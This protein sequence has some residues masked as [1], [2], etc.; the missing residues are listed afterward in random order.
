MADRKIE[1]PEGVPALNTYY[2]YLTGGCNLACQHC[3]LT[4]AYQAN[5]GTGGHLDYDLFALAIEEGLPLGLGNVKLTGGEPLLHPDFIRIVDLLREKELGLTIET[6]GVLMT[7]PLAHYLKEKST[8][9]HISVSLDGAT[10]GTHDPFRG[11][12]GSFDKAVQGIRY[13]VEAGFHPQVI[14][15]LHIGNVDEIEALIQLAV[16]SGA[17]SVK[18][19]L[20]QPTGRGELMTKRGRVLDIQRLIELGKWVEGDLQKRTSISLHYSWPMAFYNLKRLTNSNLDTCG[21][22]GIL[23]ILSTGHLAMCGMGMQIDD[24]CYGLLGRDYIADIWMSHPLLV[25]LRR[26]LPSQLEGV[27]N[28]CIFRDR[29]LGSCIAGNY[30]Y[31]HALTAPFWFCQMA[32]DLKIFPLSRQ[33]N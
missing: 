15:S 25:Q 6:N 11:V 27:C 12:K 14:M 4:P 24:L 26:N 2:V 30:Q 33:R 3:Y 7:E 18:F 32:D 19:N 31:T 9:N 10:A 8:L 1:L 28:K 29:C 20:I 16:K 17:G 23:G 22:F 21:I 5:G 13:L